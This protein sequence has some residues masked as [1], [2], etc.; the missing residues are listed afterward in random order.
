MVVGIFFVRLQYYFGGNRERPK[1][2]VCALLIFNLV[3]GFVMILVENRHHEDSLRGI[4][5]GRGTLWGNM[6]RIGALGDNGLT[7][8]DRET[9]VRKYLVWLRGKYREKGELYERLQNLAYR[10]KHGE[11]IV[12]VCSCKPLLC[13]G[14]IIKDAIEKIAYTLP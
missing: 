8:M 12:L 11:V 3:K 2:Y 6:F 13:H 14:D 10:H 7:K 1:D 4:Y 9:V 5:I